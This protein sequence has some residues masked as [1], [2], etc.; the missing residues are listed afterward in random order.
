MHGRKRVSKRTHLIRFVDR[1]DNN[2]HDV[3]IVEMPNQKD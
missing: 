2:V 3:S 1:D